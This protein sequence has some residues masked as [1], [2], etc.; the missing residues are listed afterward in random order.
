MAG[1][2]PT[3]PFNQIKR[4]YYISVAGGGKEHS[5]AELEGRWLRKV[6]IDNG[7]T[8][9]D[10]ARNSTLWKQALTSIGQLAGNYVRQNQLDFYLNAT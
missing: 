8:P 1:V 4:E 10:K 9:T 3:K 7:G 6:I 2:D 5:L